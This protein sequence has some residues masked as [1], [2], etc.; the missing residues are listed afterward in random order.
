MGVKMAGAAYVWLMVRV[1]D[2]QQRVGTNS[3]RPV[4]IRQT[5][6]ASQPHS[7]AQFTSDG[8]E[9]SQVRRW[10]RHR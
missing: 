9:L 10:K 6:N 3:L 1:S 7:D 4:T 2:R 5:L 8:A